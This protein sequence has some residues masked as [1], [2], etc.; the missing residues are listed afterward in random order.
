MDGKLRVL[1]ADDEAL[2]LQRVMQEL[3]VLP[4]IDVVGLARNGDAALGEAR[5][6]HPDLVIIDAEIP[7]RDGLS[8]AAELQHEHGP[9]II[10]LSAFERHATVAF[11]VEALDYLLKPLRPDRLGKALER[12]RRRCT[13]K[14]ARLAMLIGETGGAA[15]PMIHIPDRHGGRD[16]PVSEI[17]WIEAARDYALIHTRKHTH[18]LRATMT[19]LAA[20]WR[21]T[22]LRVHRSACVALAQVRHWAIPSN[23]MHGL[24]LSDGVEIRV[25]PSYLRQV[26]AALRSLN[27]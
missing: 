2:V 23:G 4:D 6:L 26:R 12:A 8:V 25:G 19:E 9:E 1:L 10:I 7:G 24:I 21:G 22:M 14:A 11:E 3:Y 13:E 15:P 16:L 18:I 17:I 5:R 20:Q 27:E